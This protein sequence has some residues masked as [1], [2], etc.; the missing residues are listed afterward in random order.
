VTD[1]LRE[2]FELG[3]YR[4]EAT[5][6]SQATGTVYRASHIATGQTVALHLIAGRLAND[7]VFRERFHRELQILSALSNPYLLKLYETGEEHGADEFDP[8]RL[9]AAIAPSPG[10]DLAT[11]SLHQ[12]KLTA[13]QSAHL[14]AQAAEALE[15]A[16]GAG[17]LHR[18]IEPG[19]ILVDESDRSAHLGG[20]GLVDD[21][22]IEGGTGDIHRS[23]Y[24]PSP[25]YVAPEQITGKPV[26]RRSDVYALGGVLYFAL[27]GRPPFQGSSIED[28]LNGHLRGEVPVPSGVISNTPETLDGVV[29]R[30]L[31]KDPSDRYAS[32]TQMADDLLLNVGAPPRRPQRTPQPIAAPPPRVS[33]E[34]QAPPEPA[35]QGTAEEKQR[36]IQAWTDAVSAGGRLWS[37]SAAGSNVAAAGSAAAPAPGEDGPAPQGDFSQFDDARRRRATQKGP[38]VPDA[39]PESDPGEAPP[40]PE[41]GTP[42]PPQPSSQKRTPQLVEAPGPPKSTSSGASHSGRNALIALGAA[43][44]IAVLAIGGIVLAGIGG[45]DDEGGDMAAAPQRPAADAPEQPAAKKEAA[46]DEQPEANTRDSPKPQISLIPWPDREGYTAVVYANPSDKAAATAR[47]RK[48]AAAGVKAGVLRSDS[49]G[50]L[51]PGFWVAFAGVYGSSQEAQRAADRMKRKNVAGQPYVRRIAAQP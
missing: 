42:E 48:A 3:G 44:V 20:F 46:A 2:G 29:A 19:S 36:V 31:A 51:Q 23:A 34:T 25:D 15:E 5:T 33:P 22:A 16:H 41:A 32:A 14:I 45:G 21:G 17:V 13:A 30:A 12:D 39:P 11:V 43:A 27:T 26:D 35:Q 6:G 49:H 9:W 8:I 37:P 4:I 10:P 18:G 7:A 38:P 28:I 24:P 47:A 1:A 50:S 40:E